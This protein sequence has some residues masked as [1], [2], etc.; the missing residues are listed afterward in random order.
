MFPLRYERFALKPGVEVE[1]WHRGCIIEEIQIR[2]FDM[3]IQGKFPLFQWMK[4][5][6]STYQDDL[7]ILGTSFDRGGSPSRLG[8]ASKRKGVVMKKERY[9][10]TVAILLLLASGCRQDRTALRQE[11]EV[12]AKTPVV[13]PERSEPR[14]LE[15]PVKEPEAT[16]AEKTE[17]LPTVLLQGHS[18]G[19]EEVTRTQV[20]GEATVA[21]EAAEEAATQIPTEVTPDPLSPREHYRLGREAFAKRIYEEAVMH[22]D[23]AEPSYTRSVSFYYLRGLANWKSGRVEDAI[24]D[25][26][27]TSELDPTHLRA[28]INLAR[29]L[30]DRQAPREALEAVDAAIAIEE[31]SSSAWNVKGRALAM[32][33]DT[34]GAIE[35]YRNA[36]AYDETNG[37]AWN[38][39]GYLYIGEERFEEARDCLE[40]AV[41]QGLKTPYLFN[42]LGIAR[43]RTGDREGARVAYVKAIDL[44]P[45]HERAAANL[46]RVGGPF[47][48]GMGK[49]G[50]IVA[51]RDQEAPESLPPAEGAKILDPTDSEVL[52]SSEKEATIS[53][54]LV[55]P[56]TV[57][58]GEET[59]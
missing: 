18:E 27:R 7:S 3:C 37:Y 29:A 15:E 38:N 57:R 19:E 44:D 35:A 9:I 23:A 50:T 48:E 28:R 54:V 6:L 13:A 45:Q 21:V 31:S 34:E 25:L 5:P 39:L 40:Q 36:I 51:D 41:A 22:F 4:N 47:P 59:P 56:S 2:K 43:E 49:G 42:N 10:G 26:R 11:D 12:H 55:T 30:L 46:A 8:K 52:E 53:A 24:S 20:V 1:V 58:E 17:P 33:G 16:V 32:L 14:H